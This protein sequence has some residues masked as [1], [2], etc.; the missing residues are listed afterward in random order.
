MSGDRDSLTAAPVRGW[1]AGWRGRGWLALLTAAYLAAF[2]WKP[3][4]FFVLGVEHFDR[5]FVD[6]FAL[7]A[8]NDAV[9][10]GLNP[11]ANNPLDYFGRPHVY[12]HWWLH[13][14]DFGLT[15]A[16]SQWL[17]LSLVITF[18]LAALWR[19][20][21]QAPGQLLWYLSVLC[22]S[23]VVLAVDR[24]NNDLVIFILLSPLVPCL[25]SRHRWVRLL[26]P[27]LVM[28]AAMLK[29]YPAAAALLMLAYADRSEL[30][31]RL[32]IMLLLLAVAAYSVAGDLAG[33][34]PI[35]PQPSGL[36]AFGAVGLFNE[37]GWT[38][39]GPKLVVAGIGLASVLVC[40]RRQ[41]LGD[42]EPAPSQRSD[43]L[44]FMLGS[45]L[46][47]GCFF[48]SMNFAY[49]WIF[50]IWLAPALWLLPRDPGTP[51]PVRKLAR[52]AMW[53]LVLMLWWSPVSCF[54]VNRFI[55]VLPGPKIMKLAEW[56]FLLEQPFDWAF[57]LC[58]LVFLT[59][60]TRRGLAALGQT[61]PADAA[62][63][64]SLRVQPD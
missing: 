50:S 49:R 11:Y 9:G 54:I 48:T 56:A 61:R 3:K 23:A 62:G 57:F 33:F 1:L 20:R 24:G 51:A 13:L 40:W 28:V 39:W 42:W 15:R 14:R 36:M 21:P 29:Y 25:L 53:L 52:A 46:L 17:G 60:F 47:A 8:S 30:R 22:C 10:R 43:W 55:G 44:H 16:D 64:R 45:V 18:L 34:G 38:G 63:A 6:T 32:L 58:L 27:F 5:W 41:I 4:L 19:L 59:H 7:L 35:A 26:A 12:S 2:A 31:S 37:L